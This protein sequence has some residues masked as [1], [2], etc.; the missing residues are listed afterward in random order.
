MALRKQGWSAVA[1]SW[2]C[3]IAPLTADQSGADQITKASRSR[4]RRIY[5]AQPP[6]EGN[7][8][9]VWLSFVQQPAQ[10]RVTNRTASSNKRDRSSNPRW[11]VA[12]G[13]APQPPRRSTSR[14][15]ADSAAE[16]AGGDRDL[17]AASAFGRQDGFVGTVEQISSVTASG[18]AR[19]HPNADSGGDR[20]VANREATTQ[21]RLELLS[22]CFC[23]IDRHGPV[24]DNN[25]LPTDSGSH[26]AIPCPLSN[27]PLHPL[28]AASI[29]AHGNQSG[30]FPGCY[31]PSLLP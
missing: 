20:I 8:V 11:G 14:P 13:P 22:K 17:V 3:L 2:S 12:N 30:E 9:T 18:G 24:R 21:L 5:K 1:Q 16:A 23:G 27:C 25:E 28:R 6:A 31:V 15:W 26:A 19:R 4:N 10:L 7:E 29:A